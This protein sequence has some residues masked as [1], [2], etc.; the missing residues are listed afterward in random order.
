MNKKR[1]TMTFIVDEDKGGLE[2][3]S[4]F[5]EQTRDYVLDMF[6]PADVAYEDTKIEDIE[7]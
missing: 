3:A 4:D 7:K 6:D 5:A 2:A 1:V